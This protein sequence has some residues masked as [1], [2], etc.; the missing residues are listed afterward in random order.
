MRIIRLTY[1][2]RE[3]NRPPADEAIAGGGLLLAWHCYL[4]I[5]AINRAPSRYTALA[6]VSRK[7]RII[8][9]TLE[10]LGWRVV[11]GS[12]TDGA[13]SS[14]RTMLKL[15]AQEV[16]VVIT[17]DGPQGP[18]KQIKLGAVMLQQ[19]SGLP[20]I[21]VGIK[22]SWKYTFAHS[23]DK[24]EIPLPGSRIVI[25]YGEPIK[26]LAGLDRAKAARRINQALYDAEA[27]AEQ[28]AAKR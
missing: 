11:S 15:L 26:D 3:I 9:R 6:G 14:L 18:P 25:H 22:A 1:R 20:I 13:L 5:L 7:G 8:S 4:W 24:F 23:W 27:A 19:R 10:R 28:A 12:S 16:R 17:P 2:V 21:P